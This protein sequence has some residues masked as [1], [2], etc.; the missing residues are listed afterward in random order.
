[1]NGMKEIGKRL[2][3]KI[4]DILQTSQ[5]HL[6][7]QFDVAPARFNGGKSDVGFRQPAPG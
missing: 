7:R 4:N 2:R 5:D 6:N 3:R 1:M